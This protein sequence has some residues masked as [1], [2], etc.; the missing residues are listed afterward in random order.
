MERT[1]IMLPAALR[2]KAKRLAKHRGVTLAELVRSTLE[3]EVG[4]GR[5]REPIFEDV[6]YPRRRGM[7]G[8]DLVDADLYG[9][10]RVGKRR[11]SPR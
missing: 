2:A 11:W 4:K 8:V 3:A 9:P 1:T 10:T 5:K 6:S 7:E